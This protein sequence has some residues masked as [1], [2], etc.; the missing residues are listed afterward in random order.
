MVCYCGVI[1]LHSPLHRSR[2]LNSGR[3]DCVTRVFACWAIWPFVFKYRHS[4]KVLWNLYVILICISFKQFSCIYSSFVHHHLENIYSIHLTTWQWIYL[5]FWCLIFELLCVT[6]IDLSDEYLGNIFLPLCWHVTPLTP[7]YCA[8]FGGV[9]VWFLSLFLFCL[10][11]VG[12]W[13]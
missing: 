6:D 3:Q 8:L 1:S 10:C 9:V 13:T 2:V 5:L 12:D 7:Q 11:S 4:D